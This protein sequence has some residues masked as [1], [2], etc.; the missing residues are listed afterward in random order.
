MRI[1]GVKLRIK[2]NFFILIFGIVS[3]KFPASA[4]FIDSI[5]CKNDTT[6]KYAFFNPDKRNQCDKLIYILD[7]AGR[8]SVAMQKFKKLAEEHE[9]LLACSYS[10]TNGPIKYNEKVFR[11]VIRD[12]SDRY[13]YP[14]NNFYLA[15]FSGGSR[16]AF[17]I[18]KNN[19]HI[20]DGIIGCGSALPPNTI[21]NKELNFLY[22]GIIGVEDMN[23]Y[24][25]YDLSMK[26][27]PVQSK[28]LFIY[29]NGGHTW[30]PE[31]SLSLALEW[32][33]IQ[34]TDSLDKKFS[35][36]QDQHNERYINAMVECSKYLERQVQLKIFEDFTATFKGSENTLSSLDSAG[37]F[38]NNIVI[39]KNAKKFN[40]AKKVFYEKQLKYINAF[41]KVANYEFRPDEIQ[42]IS[43]WND[44][45]RFI[46]GLIRK[47]ELESSLLG[48]RMLDFIW[49]MCA[50]QGYVSFDQGHYK[51][52]IEFNRIWK[53]V[54][55]D[56]FYPYLRS[57]RSYLKISQPELAI[58]ELKNAAKK[59]F[60]DRKYLQ[61]YFES[62]I[63]DKNFDK[64]LSDL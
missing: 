13:N 7:P 49:R 64:L 24:E 29:F 17:A 52:T 4:D 61:L 59:G 41:R 55:T 3:S 6:I 8:V 62:L 37:T 50:E 25:M 27:D 40:A 51:S 20:I 38:I 28:S 44:E 18:G 48:K 19:Q 36:L 39:E 47:K 30:P 43:W 14:I 32:L 12:I 35:A 45:I 33:S 9:Y 46:N 60:N 56:S 57:A 2:F 63:G 10:S 16:A 22:A 54:Q 5:E 53:I 31:E 15:G 21:I 26:L 34:K 42:N 58:R 23:F 1:I 11:E